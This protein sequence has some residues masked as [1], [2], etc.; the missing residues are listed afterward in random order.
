MS[1]TENT[2]GIVLQESPHSD[3]TSSEVTGHDRRQQELNKK[4]FL[5]LVGS[6]LAQLPI[7]GTLILCLSSLD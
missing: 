2:N 6:A 5:A 1:Q 3:F 7:W 4:R